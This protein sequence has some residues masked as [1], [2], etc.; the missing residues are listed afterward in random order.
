MGVL[1]GWND[2]SCMATES[3]FPA[4]LVQSGLSEFIIVI[5]SLHSRFSLALL[6]FF[7]LGIAS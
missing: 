2:L 3:A 4:W 5:Y 6:L 7:V 1:C